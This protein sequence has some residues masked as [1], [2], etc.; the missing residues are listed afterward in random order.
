[1]LIIIHRMDGWGSL[2]AASNTVMGTAAMARGGGSILVG[3]RHVLRVLQHCLSSDHVR[4]HGRF[5]AM[6]ELPAITG[7]DM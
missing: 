1:M 7:A 2:S 3:R 4:L 6:A 5:G